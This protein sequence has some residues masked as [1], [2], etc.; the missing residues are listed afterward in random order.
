MASTRQIDPVTSWTPQGAMEADR[1]QLHNFSGY[2]FDGADT[3]E[4]AYRLLSPNEDG[5]LFTTVASGSVNVPDSVVQTW[6]EDDEVIFDHVLAQL[7][8]TKATE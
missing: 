7:G 5:T 2:H 8:L 6:G 3:A 4:V 1:I